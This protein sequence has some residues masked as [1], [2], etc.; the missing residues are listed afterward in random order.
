MLLTVII[1]KALAEISLVALLAQ[2][3]L[4]LF[5]GAT[6][7]RNLIYNLFA[8]INR[9]VLRATRFAAPRFVAD[10]HIGLLAF[11]LVGVMWFALLLAKVHFYLQQ[12][13]AAR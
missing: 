2:G 10:Q 13:G 8:T 4:A 6:R 9:P 11:F 3:L 7:D 12:A 1:L 5:A